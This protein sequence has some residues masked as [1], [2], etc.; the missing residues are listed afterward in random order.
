MN[1]VSIQIKLD[2]LEHKIKVLKQKIEEK[3]YRELIYIDDIIYVKDING[4]VYDI[5]GSNKK[6]GLHI[7]NQFIACEFDEELMID[8]YV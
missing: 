3:F 6:I 2:K 8:S 5:F 7:N 4:C 1:S